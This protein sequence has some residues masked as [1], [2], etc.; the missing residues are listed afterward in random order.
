MYLYLW[1]VQA[2]LGH[3]AWRNDMKIA[4]GKKNPGIDWL[5]NVLSLSFKSLYEAKQQ[6]KPALT[7]PHLVSS[8]FLTSIGYKGFW[9]YSITKVWSVDHII[10][11][12]Y[13]NWCGAIGGLQK[14]RAVYR[15]KWTSLCQYS[16]NFINFAFVVLCFGG[17]IEP[18]LRQR[19][20]NIKNN[21]HLVGD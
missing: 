4:Q 18:C 21:Y 10:I 1:H 17:L 9:W 13:I 15:Y 20:P 7:K 8:H 5:L 16:S 6:N 2:F 14:C 12:I 11:V 19:N 3:C